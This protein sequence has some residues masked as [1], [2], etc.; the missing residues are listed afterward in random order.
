MQ[1]KYIKD[2]ITIKALRDFIL[3]NGVSERDVIFLHFVDFD[4]IVLEYRA[5]Y[6]E[7]IQIPYTII[8]VLIKEDRTAKVREGQIG[9]VVGRG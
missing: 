1:L 4:N 7:A 5:T 6:N 3:D 2:G 8:G 9:I